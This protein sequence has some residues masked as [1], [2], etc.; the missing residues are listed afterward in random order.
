MS[1]TKDHMTAFKTSRLAQILMAP[2]IAL[3]TMGIW[4]TGRHFASPKVGSLVLELM[5]KAG[6]GLQLTDSASCTTVAS[7]LPC[8]QQETQFPS[9]NLF[10]YERLARLEGRPD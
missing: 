10:A 6:D 1:A 7:K 8:P 3:V 9:T 2:T 4:V 5:W